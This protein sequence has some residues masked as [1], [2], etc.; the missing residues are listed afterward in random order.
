MADKIYDLV[1]VGAGSKNLVNA[2]YATKYGKLKV[3]LFE[4]REEAGGGWISYDSPAPGFVANHCSHVHTHPYHH[5]VVLED[6]PE[7]VDYGVQFG[8]PEV[9]VGTAFREDGTWLGFYTKWVDENCDKTYK[10]IAKVSEKDAETF[11]KLNEKWVKYI[12]PAVL[13]WSFNPP[14]PFPDALE[15]L[16][17]NPEAG[18]PPECVQMSVSQLM[19]ELFESPEA[20]TLGMR[21]AQSAG[22]PPDTY[23][24]ALIGLALI[25]THRDI[26]VVKGGTHQCAHASQRIIFENGGEIWHSAEV[27][28]IIIENGKAKGIRLKDGTEVEAKLGVVCGASP[29]QLVFELTGPE[30]WNPDIVRKVKNIEMDWIV[31]SWY[32]WALHEHPQYIGKEFDPAIE[33]VAWLTLGTKGLESIL[34][35][36]QRRRMGLWPDP[37]DL[38]LCIGNWSRF[39]PGYFAPADKCCVLTEQFVQPAYRYSE[40]EWKEIE[41]RHAEEIISFWQ[42]YAPN[43]TWDNVIG[44]VPITPYFT[45]RHAKNFAPAGN[46]CIIDMSGPQVGRFRP[47][48]ELADLRNFPIENLYPCSSAWHPAGNASSHQGYW[49]YKILAEKHNLKKP[50]EDKGRSY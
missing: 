1:Y 2:M 40:E 28:K 33:R 46:W 14:Q 43:M 15:R 31:I 42:K 4:G 49:V 44:Y 7:W 3:A 50:W 16:M 23:G 47:I 41:K 29:H 37:E 17:M 24:Q 19:R 5:G 34:K 38:Q 26:V 13:E 18:I 30:H 45:A 21:P 12:Y 36:S 20:Q 22:I 48:R 25:F 9:A 11:V 27:D 10:H 39:A 35:E 8:K 6:F 32:T